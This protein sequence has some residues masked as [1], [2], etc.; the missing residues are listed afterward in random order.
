MS[1]WQQ[2]TPKECTKVGLL[3]KLVQLPATS[4]VQT[5]HG[6]PANGPAYPGH[7]QPSA[8]PHGRHPRI[9]I[10]DPHGKVPTCEHFPHQRVVLRQKGLL[11]TGRPGLE[12]LRAKPSPARKLQ[13]SPWQLPRL[14]DAGPWDAVGDSLGNL[15]APIPKN[16]GGYSS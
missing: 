6:F 13:G 2:E 4:R 1:A 5:N 7:P 16:Q 10:G 14:Q 3:P 9:P 15:R 12:G 8:C 11:D